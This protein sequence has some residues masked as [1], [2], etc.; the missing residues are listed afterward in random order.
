MEG[1]QNWPALAATDKPFCQ[2]RNAIC[3]AMMRQMTR[4]SSSL[5][6]SLASTYMYELSG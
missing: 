3:L 6:S 1:T 5:S 2:H 4:S